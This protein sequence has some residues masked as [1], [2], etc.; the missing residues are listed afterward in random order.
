MKKGIL[1]EC[2]KCGSNS[3]SVEYEKQWIL[4]SISGCMGIIEESRDNS[5]INTC[6]RCRYMEITKALDSAPDVNL[7]NT[8]CIS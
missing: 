2:P 6:D 5:L 4:N 7:E 1:K 8:K 3:F